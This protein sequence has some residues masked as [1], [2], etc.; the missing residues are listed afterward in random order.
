MNERNEHKAMPGV[1]R[2][3]ESPSILRHSMMQW[4]TDRYSYQLMKIE[5]TNAE[6]RKKAVIPVLFG[7]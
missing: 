7:C 6:W 2:V 3:R 1:E 4:D 5:A